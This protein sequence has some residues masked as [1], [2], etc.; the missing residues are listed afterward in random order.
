MEPSGELLLKLT[1]VLLLEFET[2][3]RTISSNPSHFRCDDRGFESLYIFGLGTLKVLEKCL[4]F[5]RKYL[6]VRSPVVPM[7]FFLARSI[8]SAS[9]CRNR[10]WHRSVGGK[11]AFDKSVTAFATCI[12]W[13]CSL[14]G[15]TKIIPGL[16]KDFNFS[17]F[18]W[19]LIYKNLGLAKK[20]ICPMFE[21]C[22]IGQKKN[23]IRSFF[24]PLN[25]KRKAVW[26]ALNRTHTHFHTLCSH[27]QS[28]IRQ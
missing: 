21:R 17:S 9:L 2:P 25:R 13:F 18:Q 28:T 1:T 16:T 11:K 15:P 14:W 12:V 19:D 8:F 20:I 23:P 10:V 4:N 26:A 22:L 24:N 3:T 7:C 6:R 27:T 5:T